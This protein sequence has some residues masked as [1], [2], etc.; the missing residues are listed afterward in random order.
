VDGFVAV[1]GGVSAGCAWW[2]VV[3]CGG[4]LWFV[5]VVGGSDIRF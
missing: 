4:R 5:V 3:V 2:T 1:V